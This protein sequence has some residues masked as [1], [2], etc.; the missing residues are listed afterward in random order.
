MLSFRQGQ[1]AI[2]ADISKAFH[3]IQV[4]EQDRDYFKF[5]WFDLETEEQ[6]TFRF[7]VVMFG[8]TCLPYLL[9]ELQTHLSKNVAGCDF[10]DKFYVDNYLNTYDC[11]CDLIKQQPILDELMNEAHMPLQEWVGN[12]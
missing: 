5:L 8:A 4:N 9:Q 10:S 12:S 2:T 1:Y 6:K 7:K 11:E 3:H